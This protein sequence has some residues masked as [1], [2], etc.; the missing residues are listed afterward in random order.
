LAVLAACGRPPVHTIP[1]CDAASAPIPDGTGAFVCTPVGATI[2][3]AWPEL[4]GAITYVRPG[5]SGDGSLAAPFGTIQEAIDAGAALIMLDTGEHVLTSDIE[6]SS[7][8]SVSIIGKSGVRVVGSGVAIEVAMGELGIQD[9]VLE[10]V[11]IR[12]RAATTLNVLGVEMRAA[13]VEC[14]G[15]VLMAGLMTIA[16]STGPALFVDGSAYARI[17][18]VRIH[19]GSGVGIAVCNSNGRIAGSLVRDQIRDGIAISSTDGTGYDFEVFTSA[20]IGNGVSALRVEGAALRVELDDVL[21]AGTLVPDGLT[22]G[23]GLFVGGGAMVET[24]VT[25]ESDAQ[26]GT[27]SVF[28][29]NA[30]TGILADGA[31]TELSVRGA[32]VGSNG[33]PGIYVQ[34]SALA[35]LI[36]FSR[37]DDNLALGIGI[38]ASARAGMIPCNEIVGTR[39]DALAT[40]VGAVEVGDGLSIA[41]SEGSTEIVGNVF[42]RNERF[43]AL[44]TDANATMAD[45]TGEDNGYGMAFY[46]GSVTESGVNTIDGG[47]V[48]ETAPLAADGILPLGPVPDLTP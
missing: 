27:G 34:S 23:D 45:N 16:E 38:A 7:A 44:F 37:I 11:S 36:G 47:E 26:R 9:V 8:T 19:G 14:S 17:Y 25:I 43:A 29:G 5:A 39:N 40:E 18:G 1:T 20:S 6:I 15:C 24:D 4:I 12:A 28:I 33:G 31:G 46:G 13:N 21:L 2:M 3:P 22:G 42:S 41:S 48:P 32:L 35:S 30:R 10:G